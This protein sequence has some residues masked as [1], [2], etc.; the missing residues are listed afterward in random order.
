MF[1][2]I[3]LAIACLC[4]A[5]VY[6]ADWQIFATT[7]TDKAYF[8]FDRETVTKEG[9]TVTVW[10]KWVKDRSNVIEGSFS[11]ASKEVFICSK[12]TS[13]TMVSASYDK[14]GKFI[15]AYPIPEAVEDIVP[16]SVYAAILKVVCAPDFPKQKSGEFY[17]PATNNDV[18]KHTADLFELQR[19]QNIDPAPN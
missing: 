2:R 9:N 19:A 17:F 4:M 15:R 7:N 11:R 3:A 1:N 16:G 5:P 10:I 6:A 12:R 14:D 13:Q 18:F 8:F